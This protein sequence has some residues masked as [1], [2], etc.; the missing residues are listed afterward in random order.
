[1]QRFAGKC[2]YYIYSCAYEELGL[3]PAV[4]KGGKTQF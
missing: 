2:I 3:A 1:M 4:G